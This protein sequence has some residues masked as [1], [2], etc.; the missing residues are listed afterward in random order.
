MEFLCFDLGF[1]LLG[2]ICR[3]RFFNLSGN[4]FSGKIPPELQKSEAQFAQL[5]E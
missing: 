1:V 4:L 2:Y 5:I 3:F